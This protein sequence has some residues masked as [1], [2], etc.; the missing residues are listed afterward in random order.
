MFQ[1]L[2]SV[3]LQVYLAEQPPIYMTHCMTGVPQLK[4][5][6]N[7][8]TV[9][10]PTHVSVQKHTLNMSTLCNKSSS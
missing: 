10:S 9:K 1:K 4:S 2:S 3:W 5:C 8:L 6:V 7:N